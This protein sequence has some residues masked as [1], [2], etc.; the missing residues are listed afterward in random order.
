VT[1][2]NPDITRERASIAE[3]EHAYEVGNFTQMRRL[4][5]VLVQ[6]HDP[7]AAARARA[8][9]Q[10]VSVDPQAWFALAFAFVLACVIVHAY[11]F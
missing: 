3:A 10:K 4:C 5:V 9:M 11:V 8:L 1:Q 7:E 6:S 2:E